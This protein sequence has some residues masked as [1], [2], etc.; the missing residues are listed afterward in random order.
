MPHSAGRSS[1]PGAKPGFRGAGSSSPSDTEAFR[2]QLLSGG[3][4]GTLVLGD[5]EVESWP[6]AVRPCRGGPGKIGVPSQHPEDGIE[7][8]IHTVLPHSLPKQAEVAGQVHPQTREGAGRGGDLAKPPASAATCLTPTPHVAGD[9]GTLS[10]TPSPPGHSAWLCRGR[11]LGPPSLLAAAAPRDAR[12]SLGG[13]LVPSR[14]R[15]VSEG[16]TRTCVHTH[17]CTNVCTRTHRAQSREPRARAPR[18]TACRS[19]DPRVRG[20]RGCGSCCVR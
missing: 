12:T 17:T 1:P 8:A 3:R 15:H 11:R 19:Q 18:A 6:R 7:P 20:D 2:G 9:P 14:S 16:R 4:L 10:T 5:P 13:S